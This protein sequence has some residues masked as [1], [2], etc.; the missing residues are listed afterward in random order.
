M[1]SFNF[2]LFTKTKKRLSYNA[3]VYGAMGSGKSTLL[4]KLIEVQALFVDYVRIL[5]PS[6]E[7]QP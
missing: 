2:N 4:K 3:L 6:G 7:Y 5:D 1:G